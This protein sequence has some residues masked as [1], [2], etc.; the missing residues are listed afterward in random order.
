MKWVTRE[1]AKVDRIAC[2]WLI[3]HFIDK[4]SEFLFVPADQV[5]SVAERE[6]AISFDTPG[7]RFTHTSAGKC[8]FEVLVEHYK[9]ADRA[10]H[11]L[12]KIV[13]GAD[14]LEDI[15]ITPES[16]GLLAIAE[17]FRFISKNDYENMQRQF[18]VYDALYE[19]CKQA[20]EE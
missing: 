13:H 1:K 5:L 20:V 6:G 12:A 19:Y 7:A 16:A 15:N 4:D 11:K 14:I 9:I 8:T 2:P 10:I 17:G 3:K 18:T